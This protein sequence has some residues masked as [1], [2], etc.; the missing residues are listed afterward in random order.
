M[1]MMTTS[2]GRWRASEDGMAVKY[3]VETEVE[4][5]DDQ[6]SSGSS[7]G[8]FGYRICRRRLGHINSRRREREREHGHQSGTDKMITSQSGTMYIYTCIYQDGYF[9]FFS[10]FPHSTDHTKFDPINDS[11]HPL[12]S[13][14]PLTNLLHPIHNPIQQT[15]QL[16]AH[17]AWPIPL[18]K[19][20]TPHSDNGADAASL[21]GDV[22]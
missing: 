10:S 14:P 18:N 22:D 17:E 4:G 8:Q 7:F 21:V 11:K 3:E 2:W 12:S 15:N 20:A 9:F 1:R 19:M 13:R 16:I 6:G 5:L